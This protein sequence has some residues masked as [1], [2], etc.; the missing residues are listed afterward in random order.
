MKRLVDIYQ[1]H[2]RNLAR[3]IE[4]GDREEM[5]AARAKRREM[6]R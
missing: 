2:L 3:P 6:F 1:R 5:R 4:S